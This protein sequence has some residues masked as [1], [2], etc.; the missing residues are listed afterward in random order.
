MCK[1][2]CI[3]GHGQPPYPYPYPDPDPDPYPDFAIAIASPQGF[4]VVC[5]VKRLVN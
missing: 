1:D 4:V 3:G 5:K 2:L